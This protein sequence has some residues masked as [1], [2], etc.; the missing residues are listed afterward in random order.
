M[1][2]KNQLKSEMLGKE[3]IEIK[4]EELKQN[5]PMIPEKKQIS[6]TNELKTSKASNNIADNNHKQ[7]AK[8]PQTGEVVS[9][10]AAILAILSGIG[11]SLP[12]FKQKFK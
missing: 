9:L 5:V 7:A 10:G 2:T 1:N 4:Q 11:L 12:N 6:T 8:L 3:H